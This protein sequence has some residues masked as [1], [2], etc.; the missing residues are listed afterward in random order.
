MPLR[1]HFDRRAEGKIRIHR[2]AKADTVAIGRNFEAILV[3]SL[4]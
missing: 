1:A 2:Q 4:W 3:R